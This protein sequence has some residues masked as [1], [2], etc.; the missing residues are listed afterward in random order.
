MRALFFFYLNTKCCLQFQHLLFYSKITFD[1]ALLSA[2]QGKIY[3]CNHHQ[4]QDTEQ[5][6]ESPNFLEVPHYSCPSTTQ[7]QWQQ[8]IS[9]LSVLYFVFSRMSCSRII[10]YLTLRV[11]I[12]PLWFTMLFQVSVIYCFLLLSSSPLYGWSTICLSIHLSKGICIIFSF[13][14]CK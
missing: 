10:K 9:L 5:F 8:L 14:G 13:D 11:S 3:L 7:K 12:M 2:S 6:T 4:N 1:T